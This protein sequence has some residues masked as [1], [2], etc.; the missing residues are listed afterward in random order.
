M[1]LM[2]SF[3]SSVFLS[4]VKTYFSVTLMI[5]YRPPIDPPF[6]YSEATFL[7]KALLGFL[8]LEKGSS[9][10]MFWASDLKLLILISLITISV[11]LQKK[12]F[13]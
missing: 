13:F 10:L 2:V 7:W 5:I 6:Y 12:I 8:D 9:H 4:Y 3:R 1:I 11:N